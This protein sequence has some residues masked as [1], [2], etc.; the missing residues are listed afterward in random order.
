MKDARLPQTV[1]NLGQALER[2]GEALEEP[3][4][5]KLAID[6]TIQRFEFAIELFWKTL[7]YLLSREGVETHTPRESLQRAFQAGWLMDETAW[8][9]MLK[10]RNETSHVYDEAVAKA[11]YRRIKKHFPEMRHVYGLLKERAKSWKS[12]Q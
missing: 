2:L 6:G 5:N 3:K 4:R 8:L 1:L 7:K 9:Q 12:R 11:I 10:D